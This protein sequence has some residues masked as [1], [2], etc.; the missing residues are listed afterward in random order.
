M[1]LF[2][3]LLNLFTWIVIIRALLSWVH[4]DPNNPIIRFMDYVTEPFLHPIRRLIP[5]E[6]M[7]GLDLSPFILILII[8]GIERF[9]Y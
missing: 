7:G 9:I 6:K 5:P 2:N 4:P 8:Q 3:T 1:G